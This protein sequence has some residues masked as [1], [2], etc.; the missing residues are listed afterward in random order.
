LNVIIG[1]LF[2]GGAL[3]NFRYFFAA[4]TSAQDV[5]EVIERKPPIDNRGGGL[6]P[7]LFFQQLRFEDVS[8]AYP[9]RP[10]NMVLDRLSLVVEQNQTVA[11]VGP[12]G[13]GKSTVMHLLQRL[14]DPVSGKFN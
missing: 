4:K 12:S 11:F 13:C 10:E 1:S 2:L 14:Y 8:F 5:F 3:P 7:E 9:T 6:K